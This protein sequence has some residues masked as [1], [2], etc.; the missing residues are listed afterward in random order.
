MSQFDAD[1]FVDKER[2]LNQVSTTQAGEKIVKT[3]HVGPST[4]TIYNIQVVNGQW[5]SIARNLSGVKAWKLK[6]RE[7][8]EFEYAFVAAPTTYMT[9][10]GEAIQR[11]CAITAVYVK[12]RTAITLTMELEIWG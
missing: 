6:E 4:V 2:I 1:K 10:L 8:Q 3:S 9:S 12:R 11:D 7:G 5:N